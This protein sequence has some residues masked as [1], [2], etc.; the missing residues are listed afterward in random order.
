M[1]ADD[2]RMTADRYM[3]DCERCHGEGGPPSVWDDELNRW[4]TF[5]CGACSGR[6]YR[7]RYDFEDVEGDT[8]RGNP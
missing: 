7:W 5:I 8:S 2:P 3:V 6:G 4:H 1:T